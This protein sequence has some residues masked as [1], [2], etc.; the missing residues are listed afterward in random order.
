[1]R[2]PVLE[3]MASCILA[4]NRL[5][6]QLSVWMIAAVGAHTDPL[7]AFGGDAEHKTMFGHASE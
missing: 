1:M 4:R 6:P 7:T 2:L 3:D 5:Y